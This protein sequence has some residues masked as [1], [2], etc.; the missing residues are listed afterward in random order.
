MR[1]EAVILALQKRASARNQMPGPAAP[2]ANIAAGIV[3]PQ[4]AGNP[5]L[6]AWTDTAMAVGGRALRTAGVG[7][8]LGAFHGAVSGTLDARNKGESWRDSL[9]QGARSAA[10]SGAIGAAAGGLAGGYSQNMADKITRFGKG[11]LH[12]TT[13]WVPKG[14]LSELQGGSWLAKKQLEEAVANGHPQIDVLRKRYEALKAVEAKNLT[15][16]PG[17]VRGLLTPSRTLDT[18]QTSGR[19]LLDGTDAMGKTVMLLGATLPPALSLAV[20]RP[21]G[22]VVENAVR[23][24]VQMLLGAP[25]GA[26]TP[27]TGFVSSL[28]GN[29]ISS[30]AQRL[31]E[32]PYDEGRRLIMR[33]T[34]NDP[35]NHPTS[36]DFA[37]QVVGASRPGPVRSDRRY[38]LS[39]GA[40]A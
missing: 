14:G 1:Q 35:Q 37:Q 38:N 2:P 36:P 39:S 30:N 32:M 34:G 9:Q 27:T 31:M 25:L 26:M 29:T 17:M 16:V 10:T 4:S 15:N 20:G 28:V 22:E 5:K 18:L 6:A 23:A 24:P 7:G 21:T 12:T 3:E 33:A 19:A 11:V 40:P 13:G 8:A